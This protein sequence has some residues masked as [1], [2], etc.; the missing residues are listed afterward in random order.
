MGRT[1]PGRTM[2]TTADARPSRRRSTVYRSEVGAGYGWLLALFGIGLVG[3]LIALPTFASRNTIQD[4]IFIFYMLALAQYWNLLAGY[5]GLVSV[6]QQAFVG[7]GAY[8]LFAL[9]IFGEIDPILAIV[10]AGAFAGLCAIPTAFVVFRL[11]GA[12][13]AIGTWVMAEV[14]RLVLAQFK[15]LGGGTGTSLPPS[16]TNGV[17]GIEWV[18]TAIRCAH[19]RRPRH[20]HLLDRARTGGRH[21]ARGVLDPALA[22]RARACGDPRFRSRRRKH[23]RRQFPHQIL[24]LCLCRRRHRHG[25]RADLSAE[26]AHIAGRRL[27]G[28]RLDRLRDLH[29]G[30]RRHRHH[31]RS[32]RRRDRVLSDADLPLELRHLVPDPARRACHRDHAVRAQGHLG[33]RVGAMGA[34]AVSGAPQT[35]CHPTGVGSD[36]PV[37]EVPD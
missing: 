11:R 25:R 35:Q 9:T 13:F 1:R 4:L 18:K 10:L 22:A 21:R 14:Y 17:F 19:A 15:S 2:T 20:R 30:D 27:L 16:V 12:Y 29:R 23:G 5:A 37:H 34:G 28:A 24:G 36:K 26:G 8:L 32:D 6:G 3:L 7:L 33:L 31:R